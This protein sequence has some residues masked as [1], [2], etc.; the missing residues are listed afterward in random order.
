MVPAK[1]KRLTLI[2]LAASMLVG[3][4]VGGSVDSLLTP[5]K[6]SDVQTEVYDALVNAVGDDIV[7]EYPSGGANRSSIVIEDLDSDGSDEAIAFY[8]TTGAGMDGSEIGIRV[9]VLDVRDDKWQ[10]V[11]DVA[12]SGSSIDRVIF[13]NLSGSGRKSIII[14]YVTMSGEKRFCSYFY[15]N[16]VMESGYADSYN[17]IFVTDIDTVDGSALAVIHE[18]NSYTGKQAYFSLVCD[19]GM[20]LYEKSTV[21]LNEN[22][23]E[24][25]NVVSGYVGKETPAVFIDGLSGGQL[26]TEIIY[27]INGTLR[28][29]LY[30][31][32][33]DLV[34]ATERPRIY[35]STDIDLDGII[36]IPTLSYFPGYNQD[37][38]EGFRVTEWNVM[39]NFEI[40]K[41]YS[42]FY[43]PSDQYCFI[44]PTRWEGMVTVKNDYT[45]G[46][47]VFYKYRINLLN[48]TEELLRIAVAGT[49][50]S[51]E[52]I[53]NGYTIIKK[54]DNI[55]YLYKSS[56]NLNEPLVL[57]K[58]EILNNFYVIV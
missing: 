32:N 23:S 9:N 22:I 40:S 24:F 18:N 48:S 29:P 36:E 58:S 33:A 57:T 50:Q 7:M 13:A 56:D 54:R 14:G 30:I 55:N 53:S 10:S 5:P 27:C 25:V 1:L 42:S 12:G 15:K 20:E 4:T 31:G 16:G 39:D 41:K 45:T 26:Y 46:D 17:S 19:D 3:C 51:E 21:L 28:N 11:Y 49:E 6:L 37:S 38:R 44:L 52:L 2:L 47:I 8:Q 43:S 35:Y 34:N